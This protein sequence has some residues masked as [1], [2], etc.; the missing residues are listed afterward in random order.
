MPIPSQLDLLIGIARNSS[1]EAGRRL[2][3]LNGQMRTLQQTLQVLETY[4]A[5]YVRRYEDALKNGAQVTALQN[6][7]AFL[8][9]L[10]EAIR[11]QA[12]RLDESRRALAAGMQAWRAEQK[13]LKSFD[14]LAERKRTLERARE[15]RREQKHQ[16]EIALRLARCS[17]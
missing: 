12:T 14:A 7:R 16:D 5:D 1:D 10:D 4:R 9:T 11:Q 2:A 6:F 8:N 13:R 3:A 17:S 15:A